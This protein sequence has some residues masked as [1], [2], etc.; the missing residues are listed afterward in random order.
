[1]TSRSPSASPLTPKPTTPAA[2]GSGNTPTNLAEAVKNLSESM[3]IINPTMIRIENHHQEKKSS[4]NEYEKSGI[5]SEADIA[6]QIN[7]PPTSNSAGPQTSSTPSRSPL[8]PAPRSST[9]ST[10]SRSSPTSPPPTSISEAVR[11]ISQTMMNPIMIQATDQGANKSPNWRKIEI[12]IDDSK[13]SLSEASK[14]SIEEL[15]ENSAVSDD[16]YGSDSDYPQAF[17]N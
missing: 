16:D 9:T 6:I 14:I 13:I 4:E 15:N 11:R 1:M 5:I 12:E 17:K 2:S 7:P 10:T 8:R 3:M